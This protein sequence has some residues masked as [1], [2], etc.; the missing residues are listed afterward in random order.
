MA[1]ARNRAAT[2]LFAGKQEF[3]EIVVIHFHARI[4]GLVELAR[5][6]RE[7]YAVFLPKR[8][9]DDFFAEIFDGGGGGDEILIAGNDDGDIVNVFEPHHIDGEIDI[10]G[11][12]A[13]QLFREQVIA[14]AARA[15][16]FDLT[17]RARDSFLDY[18][19]SGESL[20]DG[21]FSA[22]QFRDDLFHAV[23]FGGHFRLI[24]GCAV[25][26]EIDKI[27]D[28]FL[29]S[30]VPIAQIFRTPLRFGKPRLGVDGVYDIP[31]R[32]REVGVD[33]RNL[34]FF[35]EIAKKS[36]PLGLPGQIILLVEQRSVLRIAP[37]AKQMA[38][39]VAQVFSVDK[40]TNSHCRVRGCGKEKGGESQ[41]QFSAD[42]C[43]ETAVP[44]CV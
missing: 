18:G 22:Q 24:V 43:A 14:D 1:R 38:D 7:Q 40:N 39:G 20:F 4:R 21:G 26:E 36:L 19:K 28:S 30:L 34:A 3:L 23:E 5:A 31:I 11:F 41:K 9:I 33:F 6:G 37:I 17:V 16:E 27:P 12:F 15:A 10:R 44:A 2:L 42:S 35:G 25:V 32:A 29:V 8:D 13:I